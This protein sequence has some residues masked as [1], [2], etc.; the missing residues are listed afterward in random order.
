MSTILVICSG[1]ICRSPLAEG[2]LAARLTRQLGPSA[3]VVSS[4]GTFGFVDRPA[5]PETV[6]AGAERGIDVSGHRSSPLDVQRIHGA[7]LIIGLTDEHREAIP[8]FAGGAEDRSFTLKEFTRLVEALPPA[9]VQTELAARVAD[10]AA[11]RASGFAGIP[12]DQDVVDPM[13]SALGTYQAVA[14]EIDEWCTRLA[15]GLYGSEVEAAGAS[16]E[17]S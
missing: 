3:P 15:D 4:A 16:E 8:T 2:F 5:M 7:D 6:Q 10:A 9:T 11:L 12:E 14:W 17:A 1:N 13:G